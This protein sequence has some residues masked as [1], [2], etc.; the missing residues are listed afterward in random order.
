MADTPTRPRSLGRRL[1]AGA[2][3]GAA[4]TA[5][6]N[7]TT[8]L[9]MAVRGR[10]PSTT[11]ERTVE[12]MAAAAGIDIP[13]TGDARTHRL[14]GLGALSGTVTGVAVGV[15]Y[16]LLVPRVVEERPAAAVPLLTLATMA[17]TNGS[18]AAYGVTDP[19]TWSASDWW[20]DLLPHLVYAAV[21]HGTVRAHSGAHEVTAGW[22]P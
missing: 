4:G 1:V 14:Q 5:A 21:V 10:P 15:A 12:A 9:D 13:G 20:S 11:P 2:V 22:I 17:A 16:R 7:A 6:L 3:A 8:Y 19:R 18:M